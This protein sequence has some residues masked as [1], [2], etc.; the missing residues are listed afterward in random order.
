MTDEEVKLVEFQNIALAEMV[1]TVLDEKQISYRER[2]DP[3]Q[4]SYLVEESSAAGS[5]SIIYVKKDILE[6]A[7]EAIKGMI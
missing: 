6:A 7:Q 1:K 4:S 2:R 5:Y 3:M